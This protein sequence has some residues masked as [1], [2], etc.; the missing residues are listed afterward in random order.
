MSTT[1]SAK[2]ITFDT[3]FNSVPTIELK[4]YDMYNKEMACPVSATNITVNGFTIPAF[5]ADTNI[6]IQYGMIPHLDWFAKV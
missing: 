1:F 2:T 6:D 4:L 5:T 3:P